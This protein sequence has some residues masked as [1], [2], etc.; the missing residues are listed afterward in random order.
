MIERSGSLPHERVDPTL[1]DGLISASR[2]AIHKTGST[3]H[4]NQSKYMPHSTRCKFRC[5]EC[6]KATDIKTQSNLFSRYCTLPMWF[7]QKELNAIFYRP[8]RLYLT[9][10]PH[11][12]P[13]HTIQLRHMQA[14]ESLC[15][16]NQSVSALPFGYVAFVA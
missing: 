1:R 3:C 15:S 13:L 7:C 14:A 4:S 9:G 10:N 16:F 2:I 11:T 12:G 5:H 8:S 6:E